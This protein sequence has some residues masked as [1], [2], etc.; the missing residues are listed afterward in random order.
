MYQIQFVA[1]CRPWFYVQVLVL[2]CIFN[3]YIH[4]L[5]NYNLKKKNNKFSKTKIYAKFFLPV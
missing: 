4:D 2:F 5:N 3:R 1:K